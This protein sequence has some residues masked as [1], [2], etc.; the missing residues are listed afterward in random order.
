MV[1]R[2]SRHAIYHEVSQ[3]LSILDFHCSLCIQ[4]HE[5]TTNLNY[6]EILRILRM[7]QKYQTIHPYSSLF[8]HTITNILMD[9]IL[10][11]PFSYQP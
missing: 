5:P 2:D 7:D 6:D 8:Y 4:F 1:A 9:L 11:H 10:Q 3:S